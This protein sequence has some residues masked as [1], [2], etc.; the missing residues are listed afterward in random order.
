MVRIPPT[1]RYPRPVILIALLSAVNCTS[2]SKGSVGG[3]GQGGAD[4]SVTGGAGGSGGSGGTGGMSGSGGAAAGG[5]GGVAGSSGASGASGSSGSSGSGGTAGSGGA[6]GG[7]G[8]TGGASSGGSGGSGGGSGG[9]GGASGGSGG[10]SGGNGGASGGSGG[11]SGGSGGSGGSVADA[12]P[13]A[14]GLVGGDGSVHYPRWAIPGPTRAT[15][16]FSMTPNTAV[17]TATC[18][19]WERAPA[20]ATYTWADAK[21]HCDTLTL[22]GFT[23]WRLPTRAELISLTDFSKYG[24]SLDKTVFTTI[25][26]SPGHIYW[27]STITKWDAN[28]YWIVAHGGLGSVSW[29]ASSSSASA[30]CVRGSGTP[31]GTRFSSPVSGVVLDSETGL[32][33]E[34]AS[35]DAHFSYAQAKNHCDTLNLGGS[36]AWRLPNIRELQTLMDPAF[37]APALPT[38]LFT[39]P[40]NY[41]WSDTLLYS[42]ATSHWG[43]GLYAGHSQEETAG[44]PYTDMRVRCVH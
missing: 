24:P 12:G 28:K 41:Y 7:S 44:N 14:A 33:W 25:L 18:L 17:D 23:D 2:S 27:A 22:D 5:S 39:V 32:Q 26:V 34:A 4:A 15:S 37:Y 30:R 8:G 10:A 35:T 13:C 31:S 1:L 19:M 21:N 42:S 40:G 29:L 9:T 16:E 36:T 43:A 3:G 20:A 11:A 6:S 38:A